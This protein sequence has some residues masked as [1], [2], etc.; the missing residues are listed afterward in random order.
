LR[1]LITGIN[2]Q[3]GS[4]LAEF[5]LDRGYEV[6]G[7]VRPDALRESSTRLWRISHLLDKILLH[8]VSLVNYVSLS[9]LVRASQPDE[10]YHLAAESYVGYG[11]QRESR[12]LEI[13]VKG[14]YYILSAIRKQAPHC[15]FYF[16]ASSE[17]FGLPAEF[18]Q[19]EVTPFRPFSAYG[20]SKLAGYHLTRNCREI[21]R[22]FSCAGIMYNHESPRRGLEYVTRKISV[23]AAR[24]KAGL[25]K[26]LRLGSLQAR[27]DWGYAPE[28]VV[29]MWRML[30]ESD[31]H[32]YVVATGTSH[33]V[34][35]FTQAAF[36]VLGLDWR[37]YVV[38]DKHLIRPAEPRRLVGDASEARKALGW[39]PTI[40]FE[41]LVRIMVEADVDRVRRN[42][43]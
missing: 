28:Y 25:A 13:N 10:C 12:A 22:L 7:V 37:D 8:P 40:S 34:E 19:N 2:G 4:Y 6:F 24:I 23:G 18:P 30:Q 41:E 27:R 33:T 39:R 29:A 1:A 17:I 42:E 3:D 20:V 35:E 26:E 21:H 16:A 15:K 14:T 32:D 11:F 36:S 31:P 38:V 43:I 9:G 5:L